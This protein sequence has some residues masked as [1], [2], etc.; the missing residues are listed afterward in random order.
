MNDEVKIL[1]A[2]I[3]DSG[4][5][6]AFLKVIAYIRGLKLEEVENEDTRR[7]RCNRRRVVAASIAL[8][9]LLALRGWYYWDKY[10]PKT[11]YFLDYVERYGVSEGVASLKKKELERIN[12]FY[13]IEE[14]G[15]V[16]TEVRCENPIGHLMP[17]DA[18]RFTDRPSHTVYPTKRAGTWI[19]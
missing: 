16:V 15:H 8:A 1:D 4:R 7:R 11:A 18:E 12:A 17:P 10:V 13:A 5:Y 9:A 2:N 6:S 19:E 14:K 3:H